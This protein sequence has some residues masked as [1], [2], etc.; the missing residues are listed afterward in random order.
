MD[1]GPFRVIW[2]AAGATIGCE[3][4][5]T[6]LAPGAAQWQ[7]CEYTYHGS[8]HNYTTTGMVDVDR[9]VDELDEDNNEYSEMV[10][11]RPP[12]L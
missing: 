10:D 9:D 4:E 5:V 7:E 2:R 11:V 8:N 1:S 6:N 3:W 12:Y